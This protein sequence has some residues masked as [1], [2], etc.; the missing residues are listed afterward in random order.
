LNGLNILYPCRFVEYEDIE[1]AAEAVFNLNGFDLVG[2][3]IKVSLAQANQVNKLSTT[4]QAI[5]NNDE[6]FQQHVT[7][8]MSQEDQD[9][10]SQQQQDQIELRNS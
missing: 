2:R 4:Q 3:A 9:K 5:W 6:W 7:G 8:K 10:V 1:D